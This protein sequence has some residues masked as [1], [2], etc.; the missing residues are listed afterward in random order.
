[1]WKILLLY[2]FTIISDAGSNFVG[3]IQKVIVDSG[4][5]KH[6]QIENKKED[7]YCDT[8]YIDF[9]MAHCWWNDD[10]ELK[11]LDYCDTLHE[12]YLD[13]FIYSD[14][15]SL[16]VWNLE[17]EKEERKKC[18]KR[19]C[20]IIVILQP[21]TNHGQQFIRIWSKIWKLY[22]EKLEMSFYWF[23]ANFIIKT[24]MISY[25]DVIVDKDVFQC[26]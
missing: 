13:Y 14:Y 12:D 23:I 3:S 17:P 24:Y 19:W 2:F 20:Y 9:I 16:N 15:C 8:L 21:K 7:G 1:M 5:M 6:N 26:L 25:I 4:T 18:F 11:T 10:D 22:F